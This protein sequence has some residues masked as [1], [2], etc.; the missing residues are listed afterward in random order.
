MDSTSGYCIKMAIK[1]IILYDFEMIE[2]L[3]HFKTGHAIWQKRKNYFPN[4]CFDF[5]LAFIFKY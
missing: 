2:L 5:W 3:S 1:I 4:R